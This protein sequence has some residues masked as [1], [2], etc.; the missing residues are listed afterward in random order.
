[1]LLDLYLEKT[2]FLGALGKGVAAFGQHVWKAPSTRKMLGHMAFGGALG[3]GKGLIF[4]ESG[5]KINS[6]LKSGATGVAGGALTGFLGRK[7]MNY[8]KMTSVSGKPQG[9]FGDVKAHLSSAGST[10]NDIGHTLKEGWNAGQDAWRTWK[11]NTAEDTGLGHFLPVTELIPIE[12]TAFAAVMKG[13]GGAAKAFWNNHGALGNLG[14]SAVKS[15][16]QG[17]LMTGTLSALGAEKG[18]RMKG[19]AKGFGVGAAGGAVGTAIKGY[20]GMVVDRLVKPDGSTRTWGEAF[21][22]TNTNLGKGLGVVA[23]R[24]RQAAAVPT[25]K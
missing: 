25:P 15:A 2:A 10:F 23:G 7:K 9:F 13:I 20:G 16:V 11:T 17:G 19:F 8:D 1:M 24:Y 5:N 21:K 12:K 14:R 4:G 3:V 22:A 6:A 18:E